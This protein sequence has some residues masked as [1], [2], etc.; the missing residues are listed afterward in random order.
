MYFD[1]RPA[2]LN[3]GEASMISAPELLGPRAQQYEQ[4]RPLLKDKTVLDVACCDGRWSAWALD[5]GAISVHGI[6]IEPRFIDGGAPIM[7]DYFPAGGYS[8][9]AVSWQDASPDLRFDVVL[10]L[11]IFY[12]QQPYEL[13]NK[14]IGWG[15]TII[16]DTPVNTLSVEADAEITLA[17]V[18]TPLEGAGFTVTAMSYPNNPE[19]Y[20]IL[21]VRT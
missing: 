18:I 20:T 8:F 3:R 6:D 17:G 5:S 21:A 4:Y 14:A 15:N 10:L 16:I 11:G 19:R 2:F 1:G 7:A 13:L 9:E 12:W